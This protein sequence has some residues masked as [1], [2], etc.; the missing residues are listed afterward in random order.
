MTESSSLVT[1]RTLRAWLAAGP[2]DRGVGSGL[3]FLAS[4]SSARAGK[5]SWVLRYRFGGR[6]REKVLG[7]YPDLTLKEARELARRDRA[8]LQQSIDVG[9][10][11]QEK[12]R[13]AAEVS[14]VEQL[15]QAWFERYI[16][17]VHKHPQ[18]VQ[19]V[20]TRHIYPAIGKIPLEQVCPAHIDQVLSGIVR[21]G[22]PTVANDA[23][24][25][26]TRMFHFALKHRRLD[27]N[28][29]AGFGPNDAGGVEAPRKRWLSQDE[30]VEL[31]TA[32]RSSEAISRIDELGVWLLLALCVRKMELLSAKW[33]EFDLP[34]GIWHLHM[35]RTKTKIG[36]DI[37]LAPQVVEWLDEVKQFAGGSA[38]LFPARRRTRTR[39]GKPC[40]NVSEHV[41]AST[42][43]TALKRLNL[44]INHFTVHDIRRTARTHLAAI[45][46][47]RFVAER[48]LNHKLGDIEGIYNQYDYFDE[49]KDALQ[50]WAMVLGP[51]SRGEPLASSVPIRTR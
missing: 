1:D 31:A 19:S 45:G 14:S 42:L 35:N 33:S 12:K 2:V 6:Q 50:R 25:H 47:D 7:R 43:N 22:Y 46:V 36:I 16:A 39:R 15:G 3:T 11:K 51:I 4:A 21:A 34:Q 17:N 10:V 8:L 20:L 5:A 48:A 30:L 13:R 24:R 23:L 44:S 18:F 41:C 37:P 32:M 29:V 40:R 49:R 26:M 27:R 9:A 38:H 28:P